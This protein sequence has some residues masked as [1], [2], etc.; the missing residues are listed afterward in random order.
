[1]LQY[2]PLDCLPSSA[3]LP[4]SDDTPVDNELQNL[5]PNLLAAILA[6]A[7]SQRTD[8]FF[9]VD[10][11]IYY[12]PSQSPLVPDGFLSL[13]VERFVDEDGRLSYVLWEEDGIV[14]VFALE[15]VSKTYGGEYEQKK[16]DYAQLGI[17]YYAI[18][19]PTRRY[20]RKRE[21]LEIYR[22]V[23]G[24]YV[25]QPG[26]RVWMPEIGLA[27]GREQGTYQGRTRE[28]L[29]WYDQE[30]RKLPTPEELAQQERQ[31]AEQLAQKLRELGIDP[32]KI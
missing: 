6:L 23:E 24:N 26:A 29:Y 25:L 22:L 11:A 20:R 3:E 4:D 14:P 18:Y 15:V 10:M 12:A 32:D 21:P 9:G 19:V 28:W 17:L 27:I 31:R 8:W 30:G 5:I 7:W 1:M 2:N 13:G 16:L